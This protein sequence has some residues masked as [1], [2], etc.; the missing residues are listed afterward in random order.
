MRYIR[1]SAK[2]VMQFDKIKTNQP[3]YNLSHLNA[4]QSTHDRYVTA[5]TNYNIEKMIRY[6]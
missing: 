2:M 6:R 3:K 4:Q 5:N 1:L